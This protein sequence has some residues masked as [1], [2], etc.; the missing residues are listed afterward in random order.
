MKIKIELDERLSQDEM[1][2]KCYEETEIIKDIIE[3]I[4]GKQYSITVYD[5][6]HMYKIL[7]S[8]ILYFDSVDSKTYV[9]LSDKVYSCDLKLYEIEEELSKND[10]IRIS[11]S[12]IL[13][14]SALMS[15]KRLLN[16]RLMAALKNG[17]EVVI[18]RSYVKS[19][20]ERFGV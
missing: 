20:K 12:C 11:K 6:G 16:G 19:F 15:V 4:N 13:N 1:I 2:I 7:I 17:E 9:Y 8:D 5:E 3:Y 10:F 18:N 14:L